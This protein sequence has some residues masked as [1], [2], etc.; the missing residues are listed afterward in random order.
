MNKNRIRMLL[1]EPDRDARRRMREEA[2]ARFLANG[3]T[4]VRPAEA[5]Y[6]NA[7]RIAGL[8]GFFGCFF[9]MLTLSLTLPLLGIA[10]AVNG[11]LGICSKIVRK[12][13][14]G[15]PVLLCLRTAGIAAVVLAILPSLLLLGFERTPALYKAKRFVFT[16]G[17]RTSELY[18]EL[19]PEEL[20]AHCTDY[21]FITQGSFPAQDYSPS[22]YLMLHTDGETLTRIEQEFIP[23]IS[24]LVR[25]DPPELDE[26]AVQSAA[27][28][29]PENRYNV[30]CPELAGHAAARLWTAGFR[31]DLT[32]AVIWR[33]SNP[34]YSKGILIHRESGLFMIWT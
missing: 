31:D 13:Q 21:C 33:T 9:W 15:R 30:Y 26:E 14:K 16:R 8:L 11:L 12:I 24:W 3:K 20:P 1:N 25:F 34:A 18:R 28:Y 4:R 5:P 27:S 23:K 6:A 17:V 29:N 32:G 7:N 19:L 10:A 22:C 2:Q